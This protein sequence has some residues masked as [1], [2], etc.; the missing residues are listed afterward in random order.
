MAYR[1]EHLKEDLIEKVAGLARQRLGTDKTDEAEFF[2]RRY[3]SNV[4]V[5]DLPHDA[6][7]LYGSALALLTFMRRRPPGTPR[8]RVFNPNLEEHGWVSDHSV[9]EMVNDDMPFL[10]DSVTAELNRLGHGVH[11]VVHP[12]L[13]VRRD[14]EGNFLGFAEGEAE[15]MLLES[16][17]H[18]EIDQISGEEHL[19][20]LARSLERVL[21]DVRVAVE[22]WPSMRRLAADVV[23]ELE[24]PPAGLAREDVD[25]VRDFITWLHDDHFTFLG[26]RLICIS[27]DD[28][29]RI[30]FDQQAGQGI[31]R[32]PS[33]RLFDEERSLSDMPGEV[34]SFLRDPDLLL[35]TKAGRHSSVHRPVPMDV[36][37][38][39]RFDAQ[40]RVVAMHVFAGLFT[41]SAYTRSPAVIPVLRRKIDRTIR[42]AGFRPLS[43]DGK[44]LRNILETYPRDELFQSE[45][46]ELFAT[47]MGILHLQERQRVALFVRRDRFERF[48][49]CLVYV[50]RDRYDTAL[51]QAVQRILEE[52][53]NGKV[54]AFYTQMAD[55]P[56]ARLHFIVSTTPG[57]AAHP[58]LPEIES[59]LTDAARDWTDHLRDVLI[60][61]SGEERG[62][63][64]ARRY[65]K[66]FPA[67]YRERQGV[68]AAVAD[69]ERAEE[70]L[71]GAPLAMTLYRPI[72]AA[73]YEARFKLYH[74]RRTV[75][76][77]QVLPM[78]ENMGFRVISEVP[79]HLWP[80]GSGDSVW[81]H[82]FHMEAVDYGA[83][84]IGSLRA[85]FH[86]AFARIWSGELENDGFNQLVLRAGLTWREV[87][88]MRAY[89]KY[90]RQLGSP[91]S[92][93]AMERALAVNAEATGA[94]IALFRALLDPDKA[95]AAEAEA[96]RERLDAVL[97]KVESADDDRILRR[98]LNLVEAT[99]RT[100][101]WQ[102][103]A[104]GG[105]KPY[106]SLKIDAA[107]VEDMPLPRPFAEIFVYSPRVEAVHLRGGK[108]ARGGI[109]WSDRR[110]DFR[111]EILGLIKAQLVKNA[112]IVPVGAKGGFVVKNPPV[113]GGREAVMAEG[114]ECYRIMMRG[115]L[116]ITDNLTPDG[117]VPP[118]QVTR[119]DGDDP[120]LVVAADKG[121]ATFSDIANGI[122]REYGFWLDDAFAS[123]GSKGYD[124]KAM[125]I[126]AR[127]AW[128]A[129]K[130]HFR[131][132]GVD[133]QSQDFTV[134]GIGDMSGDVFGNG[135][136]LSPHIRLVAAFDHRHI[137]IDPS[138]DAAR[139]FEERKRLF[140][141]PRSSWADYDPSLI[142]QGGGIFP[143]T[144]KSIPVSPEMRALLDLKGESISPIELIRA[145]LTARVDLLWFGGIGTYVKSSAESQAEAGDRANDALR[146]DGRDLRAKVVGEGA[147]LGVTQLGR[148]EYALKGGRIN[149]DAIDNSAGVDTSDHEVNIKILLNE[150][151]ATGDMTG[152]Q[153]D[154]LLAAMTDEVAELVL[155]HNYLQTQAITRIE[156]QAP[157]ILDQHVRLMR[158]LEKA[159]RLNRAIEF[160]PDDEALA[161][162][163]AA[164]Q[165]L[166]RPEIAV[167]FG[168]SKI[169][170][171]DQLLAGD[172][173]DDPLL[174]EDLE[175]YFPAVLAERFQPRL[176]NHRLRREIVATHVTN[177]M[178]NRV[179]GTFVT[180]MMD[181]TGASPTDVARA[182][183]VARDAFGL[184][185]I[186]DAIEKLDNQ[187]PAAVQTAMAVEANRLIE[188]ATAWI[189]RYG[190]KPLEISPARAELAPGLEA[191]RSCFDEILPQSLAE[192]VGQRAQEYIGQGVPEE[193]ARRV[194]S[195]VVLA[196][197]CD[198]VRIAASRDLVVAEAG[199]L[200]FAVGTRFGLG[201][202]RGAAEH[203]PVVGG[204]QKLA[205]AAMIEELYAHQR[206]IARAVA[207][208]TDRDLSPEEAVTAWAEHQSGRER[209]EQLLAELRLAG[210]VDLAMLAVA[211]RQFRAFCE[212]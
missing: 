30:G 14:E 64:L 81:I 75:P 158:M 117:V 162:R 71:A 78:L 192:S 121:T 193:L 157:E 110:E 153:R 23:T 25:E 206:D 72:E 55:S 35:I 145:I 201:W 139:S 33:V 210:Q 179:G 97:D 38:V 101:F 59:R 36:V 198:I 24:E 8:L 92:Q 116:D 204:W 119:R 32:D 156:A 109:R 112:V 178:I 12:I 118:P 134:A 205:V 173:P 7:S 84:D 66:A 94:I 87:T 104:D 29:V 105:S 132:I 122:A 130:R 209:T 15:G 203:I 181:R 114:I 51:R 140:A 182:Y 168:Y 120:Y 5:D 49:S 43:H 123:G 165:G 102:T 196:S 161:E 103:G 20:G 207:D 91:Y 31:L 34:V 45:D 177:S 152:K 68:Q 147:N 199:R 160:L 3:F 80:E 191:L 211:N 53:F 58:H 60:A 70:V 131:E 61:A 133:I 10:V 85:R 44:A 100:N 208:S 107:R 172:L 136:L 108:V 96:I 111:T 163:A 73:E 77:S 138:P 46:E 195:L 175:R 151:V 6:E 125:G 98:F 148:I 83:I 164:H 54:T 76:L 144:A 180:E 189:L 171:Y 40:G 47:A 184:R 167:I 2:I 169:W 90:L 21:A 212:G 1:V 188:R 37:G 129:V 99:L 150:I 113:G 135:M 115:L 42:R 202:L 26:Y 63:A 166:T 62:L 194:A 106:L 127:G 82:D 95:D 27:G 197:G 22:D 52:A 17:I 56:L 200:Y 9:V 142:S 74:A 11:M 128:E 176:R 154:E 39:K 19:A 4:P 170:L 93:Q 57:E 185:E 159:G 190:P 50:P 28:P 126:T 69:I 13:P 183:I 143:R 86:E 174:V 89:G 155:R 79:H 48:I 141:L 146:V 124:H 88:L 149:T 67:S 187:V 186:W 65:G 41:S 18:I 137:F 16:V